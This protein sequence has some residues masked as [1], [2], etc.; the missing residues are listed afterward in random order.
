[1]NTIHCPHPR[2]KLVVYTVPGTEY[3]YGTF[4]L[5]NCTHRTKM[6]L[7][8]HSLCLSVSLRLFSREPNVRPKFQYEYSYLYPVDDWYSGDKYSII[9][10]Y[11]VL[12]SMAIGRLL[13]TYWS[14]AYVQVYT[15]KQQR[16]SCH[17]MIG[18]PLQYTQYEYRV[19]EGTRTPQY[20]PSA[21][22]PITFTYFLY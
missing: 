17:G 10:Q 11:S 8:N 14:K 16:L 19:L 7:I 9:G 21:P 15:V 1:M 4:V 2:P 20:C 22:W 12:A 3:R 13:S 5:P 6:S 18:P